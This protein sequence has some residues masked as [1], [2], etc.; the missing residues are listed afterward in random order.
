[1]CNDHNCLVVKVY[2]MCCKYIVIRKMGFVSISQ[3]TSHLV[4]CDIVQ[5]IYRIHFSINLA[6][7]F[8]F[9][10]NDLVDCG[11]TQE[12]HLGMF[13]LLTLSR[14]IYDQT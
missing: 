8:V 12:L 4:N 3:C 14:E 13:C 1:M 9:K 5:W 2:D 10:F 11:K 7:R 6:C